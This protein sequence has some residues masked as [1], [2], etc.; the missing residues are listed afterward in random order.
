MEETPTTERKQM[1]H[2]DKDNEDDI[3]ISQLCKKISKSTYR[4]SRHSN[5]QIENNENSDA[6]DIPCLE[7]QYQGIFSLHF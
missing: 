7:N 2:I 6:N 5:M 3:P 1:G 4:G